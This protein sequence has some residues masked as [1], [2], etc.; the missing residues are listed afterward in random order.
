MCL[1]CAGQ[2]GGRKGLVYS[3]DGGAPAL[4]GTDRLNQIDGIRGL[5]PYG[6]WVMRSRVSGGDDIALQGWGDDAQGGENLSICQRLLLVGW[7]VTVG[8]WAAEQLTP[9][10][11]GA[12]RVKWLM[13][14]GTT[15][16]PRDL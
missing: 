16:P 14:N 7:E 10:L 2:K 11:S 8:R 5:G 12:G 9:L 1:F 15:A 6:G 3:G 4:C 13:G